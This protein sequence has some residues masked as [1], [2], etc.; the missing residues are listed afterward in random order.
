MSSANHNSNPE[1]RTLPQYSE[2]A[3]LA[4]SYKTNDS[5]KLP[6]KKE[7][8]PKEKLA[9]LEEFRSEHESGKDFEDWHLGVGAPGTRLG[10]EPGISSAIDSSKLL[11]R[12]G[13]MMGGSKSK[14][15]ENI[16]H[17]K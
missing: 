7:L 4:P 6:Q 5:S 9:M 13:E 11:H 1:S 12:V 17:Q 2:T 14:V 16:K 15:E 10:G 8:S 3:S